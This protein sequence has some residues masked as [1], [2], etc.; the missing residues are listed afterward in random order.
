MIG[1]VNIAENDDEADAGEE[2]SSENE[3]DDDPRITEYISRRE[4][5]KNRSER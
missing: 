1:T 4:I 5:T 3:H 2:F